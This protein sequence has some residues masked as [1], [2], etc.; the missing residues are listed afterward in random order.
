VDPDIYS[1]YQFWVKVKQEMATPLPLPGLSLGLPLTAT[2][3]ERRLVPFSVT[4]Q[5]ANNSSYLETSQKQ[6]NIVAVF[7]LT[8]EDMN[9]K[10]T[11]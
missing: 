1:A 4:S 3:A 11:I 2:A 9:R 7:Q 10:T 8:M 6:K 5:L